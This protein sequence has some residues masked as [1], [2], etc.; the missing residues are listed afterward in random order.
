M[1]K[2]NN[3]TFCY[4]NNV[5]NMLR[6]PDLDVKQGEHFLVLGNSGCGK[7]T[8]L[9]LTAGLLKPQ[10]GNIIIGDTDLTNL[11]ASKLDHFRGKNIG[12]IFQKPHFVRS[13]TVEENLYAA[14][15]LGG[16]KQ[17]KRRVE[18][19]LGRLNIAHKLKASMFALSEGEK[20]RVSVAMA[21][22][23]RPKVVLADEPTASLDDENARE[24][25]NLLEHH[26]AEENAT[27]IIVTHDNRLKAQFPQQLQLQPQTSDIRQ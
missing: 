27:L 12:I 7:T 25:A 4:K 5:A 23:N 17:D 11:S 26:S 18:E 16:V 22:I 3:L 10:N 8:F 14:Q 13:L 15:Y 2:T 24:V 6:F 19:V 9:H 20:Q 21:L 1:L